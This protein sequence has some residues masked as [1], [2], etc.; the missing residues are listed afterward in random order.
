MNVTN[1]KKTSILIASAIATAAFMVI[2][3]MAGANQVF[4]LG[5]FHEVDNGLSSQEFDKF[6]D[7]LSDL[8]HES[9]DIKEE[10]IEDCI[11]YAYN[12]ESDESSREDNEDGEDDDRE[13]MLSEEE[14]KREL[15]EDLAFFGDESEDSSSNNLNGDTDSAEDENS[16]TDNEDSSTGQ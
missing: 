12:G 8:E 3:P 4:G 13:D 5:H 15:K 1:N 7:C 6:E 9:D 11:D 14:D 16:S 10:E 2:G